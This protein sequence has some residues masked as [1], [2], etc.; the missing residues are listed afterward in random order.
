MTPEAWA[1]IEGAC[2][3][4]NVVCTVV[5]A[6]ATWTGFRTLRA[7]ENAL[8][9]AKDT[10]SLS[11][12]SLAD[13][14]RRMKVVTAIE[15]NERFNREFVPLARSLWEAYSAEYMA[16]MTTSGDTLFRLRPAIVDEGERLGNLLESWALFVLNDLADE[17]LLSRVAG[18]SYCQQVQHL[19]TFSGHT[20]A[21]ARVAWPAVYEIS[22]RWG[23]QLPN[24][25]E[26]VAAETRRLLRER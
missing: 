25:L 20:L 4:V 5:I 1:A 24:L 17:S 10:L 19:N 18:P 3:I 11:R 14:K 6:R 26:E 8:V 13:E 15:I 12:E 7:T 16:F 22:D 21:S 9:V 23:P 2:A